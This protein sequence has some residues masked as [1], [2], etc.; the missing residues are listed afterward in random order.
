[1]IF[2][3]VALRF[4]M[5]SASAVSFSMS[6]VDDNDPPA[7]DLGLSLPSTCAKLVQAGHGDT[8]VQVSN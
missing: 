3:H 8:Q 1:M 5:D 7:F 6:L 4:R 2:C